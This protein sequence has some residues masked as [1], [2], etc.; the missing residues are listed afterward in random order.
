MVKTK[1][2][3]MTVS[4]LVSSIMIVIKIA[5]WK[6]KYKLANH[7]KHHHHP[8]PPKDNK[9][10]TRISQTKPT[11][12]CACPD[13]MKLSKDWRT[14]VAKTPAQKAPTTPVVPPK[15]KPSGKTTPETTETE[16]ILHGEAAVKPVAQEDAR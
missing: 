5:N 12:S 16:T 3:D 7:H 6:R 4:T 13:D 9:K 2:N 15:K 11:T 1:K 8:G 10:P 14:C